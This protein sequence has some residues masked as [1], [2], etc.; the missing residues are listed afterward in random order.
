MTSVEYVLALI[1][2]LLVAAY[3]DRWARGHDHPTRYR[4]STCKGDHR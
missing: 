3:V 1:A 4:C 2:I